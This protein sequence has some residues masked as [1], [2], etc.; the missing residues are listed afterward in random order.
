MQIR[1]ESIVAESAFQFFY[2]CPYLRANKSVHS[3]GGKAFELTELWRHSGRC[4]DEAIGI[5][6]SDNGCGP[7]FV[8]GVDIGEEETYC[9]GVDTSCS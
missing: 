3:G 1:L 2:I 7:V 9:D 5:F 6:L 8:H 4:G